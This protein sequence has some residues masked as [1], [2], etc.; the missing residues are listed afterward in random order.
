MKAVFITVEAQRDLAEIEDYL[1]REAP[2][3]ADQLLDRLED[4]CHDLASQALLYPLFP[5]REE[6]GVRR[7]VVYPYNIMYRVNG[8]NVEIVHVL[9]GARDADRILFPED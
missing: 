9:H 6:R 2:F 3:Q 1:H 7:R 8:D 5:G 4:A